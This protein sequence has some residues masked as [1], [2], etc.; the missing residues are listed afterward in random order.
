MSRAPYTLRA[1]SLRTSVGSAA[2]T[3][4]HVCPCTRK[5]QMRFL[6]AMV[7]GIRSFRSI[8]AIVVESPHAK[9]TAAGPTSAHLLLS[10]WM[11]LPAAAAVRKEL[12]SY[13]PR[14]AATPRLFPT[15]HIPSGSPR[16]GGAS[17]LACSPRA[18][19]TR[20]PRVSAP[21]SG[22]LSRPPAVRRAPPLLSRAPVAACGR[23][24]PW[25]TVAVPWRAA[26]P[27]TSAGTGACQGGPRPPR[28]K[29]FTAAATAAV[30]RAP[31][32]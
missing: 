25:G 26:C 30:C 29:M 17:S 21:S 23:T 14:P 2:R 13:C 1:A 6:K 8:L 22:A 9:G 20:A 28:R 27:C 10:E 11:A 7:Q 19:R 12:S 16:T 24:A 3:D 15:A 5:R 32:A 31:E 4:Y 18:R